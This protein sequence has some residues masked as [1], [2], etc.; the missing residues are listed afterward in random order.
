MY[1]SLRE[2]SD[3]SCTESCSGWGGRGCRGGAASR[4]QGWGSELGTWRIYVAALPVLL[5]VP[6]K[7]VCRVGKIMLEL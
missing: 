6:G 5:V 4:A 3:T 7:K 2:Q 1:G